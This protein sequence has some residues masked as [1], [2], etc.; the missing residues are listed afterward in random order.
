MVGDKPLLWLAIG[1]ASL[2]LSGCKEILGLHERLRAKSD[3]GD[4]GHSMLVPGQCGSL[5]HPSEVCAQCMD[6]NCC[7]EAE[8]CH[9][10]SSCDPAYECVAMCGDDGACRA[11]CG[12]FY[13]RTDPLLEVTA[14][15]E[16]KCSAECGFS[17]GG[18]GY[19]I[20]GCDKCIESTCC[21]NAAACA[22][23][24]DCLR[25]DLCRYNCLPGSTTCPVD[26]VSQY[27]L[28][29]GDFGALS[30][31]MNPCASACEPGH[32]WECLDTPFLWPKPHAVEKVT[33]SVTIVDLLSEKPFVGVAVKACDKTDLACAS[34]Y[35]RTTTDATGMASLS[36]PIGTVGFDG[37]LDM[38]GGD[39]GSGN[40]I[41]PA[42]WYPIPYVISGGWRGRIQFV[43]TSDLVMLA[44][45]AGAQVDSTRG[46][47]AAN[48]DDCNF[49]AADG[50][51]YTA[52]SADA[53]TK[54]F[55]FVG[56]VPSTSATETAPPSAIGG[57]LNLPPR[58]VLIKGFSSRAGGREIAE[59]TFAIRAGSFTVGTFPPG[60][61]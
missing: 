16:S 18:L 11:R 6:A 26:C 28:G 3:A 57:F 48:A 46:H 59:R 34:P 8:K 41:F 30:D 31:C 29:A 19:P 7:A 60:G 5:A 43:S 39:D 24:A 50:V 44:G 49:L 38:T 10:D 40:P 61:P 32:G 14:C 20:P 25:L 23:N 1:F 54:A 55:Y 45:A 4:A 15:R 56:G 12:L 22:Q 52:D 13:N 35:N 2:S 9:A 27:P 42:L 21:P 53:T 17:C 36:V 47:F 33:F 51:S 37:Y 58:L